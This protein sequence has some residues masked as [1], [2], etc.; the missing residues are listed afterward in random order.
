MIRAGDLDQKITIIGRLADQRDAY[1]GV[2]EETGEIASVWASVGEPTFADTARAQLLG[3]EAQ[4]RF[5][6]RYRDDL[7]TDMKVMWR[8][9][10]FEIISITAKGATQLA[11]VARA[12]N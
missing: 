12:V 6:I 3:S 9:N 1:G 7:T 8:R 5:V 10:E 11:I 4:V 2:V